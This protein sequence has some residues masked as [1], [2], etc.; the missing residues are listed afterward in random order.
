MIPS[1]LSFRAT[2]DAVARFAIN[3]CWSFFPNIQCVTLYSHVRGGRRQRCYKNHSSNCLFVA[4]KF[5]FGMKFVGKKMFTKF[6]DFPFQKFVVVF[7]LNFLKIPFYF[8]KKK[9]IFQIDL[10]SSHREKHWSIKINLNSNY[11]FCTDMKYTP[12]TER[13]RKTNDVSH[14]I[15]YENGGNATHYTIVIE[16]I[17]DITQRKKRK[18]T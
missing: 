5:K 9:K 15:E 16:E 14:R 2:H 4:H 10:L 6:S 11:L 8:F 1:S 13:R 17:T 3:V 12:E 7:F 18:K